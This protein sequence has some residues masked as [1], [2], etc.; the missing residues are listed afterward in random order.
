MALTGGACAGAVRG[1]GSDGCPKDGA[2][3]EVELDEAVADGDRFRRGE[4]NL[5]L[6]GV[7]ERARCR[8]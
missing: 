7:G 3:V 8:P 5:A 4:G 1:G 6:V 2:E